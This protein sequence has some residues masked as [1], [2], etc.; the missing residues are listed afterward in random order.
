MDLQSSTFRR[1][2]R[3]DLYEVCGRRLTSEDSQGGVRGAAAG[4]DGAAAA[5][6]RGAASPPVGGTRARTPPVDAAHSTS[7]IDEP[8]ATGHGPLAT[9]HGL[10]ATGHGPPTATTLPYKSNCHTNGRRAKLY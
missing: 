3:S 7:A 4:G 2:V 10:P 5:R 9:G 1:R 6:P 8:P